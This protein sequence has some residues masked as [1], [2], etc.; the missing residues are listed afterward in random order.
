M[1][2][3]S[4]EKQNEEEG[5]PL[6]RLSPPV[7]ALLVVASL[8]LPGPT[9]AASDNAYVVIFDDASV[10]RPTADPSAARQR[11]GHF[12]MAEVD[13]ARV[14]RHVAAMERQYRVRPER[15][16]RHAV[17]GFSARLSASQ[18][19]ALR[20]DPAVAAIEPDRVVRLDEGPAAQAAYASNVSSSLQPCLAPYVPPAGTPCIPAGVRRVGATD[21]PLA[22]IDGAD[23]RVD[24]DVAIIDTGIDRNHPDLNVAGG[25]NCTTTNRSAYGDGN[26]HGTHVA[27]TVAAVDNGSGVVGVAPG[28]RLW[29]VKVLNANGSGSVSSIICGIDWVTAQRDPADVSRPLIEVANMSLRFGTLDTS[30]RDCAAPAGD[31]VLIAICRSVGGGTTYAVAAGNESNNARVYRPASYANVITV[32]ATVD[33]DGLPGGAAGRRPYTFCY[34]DPDDNFASFSS[35]GAVLQLVAPGKCV[36]STWPRAMCNNAERCYGWLSGTSMATPHVAGG[37]ALYM[38]QYPQARPQQVRMALQAAARTDWR[39]S[40]YPVSNPPRQLWL[41]QLGPPPDFDATVGAPTGSG[42]L[43]TGSS[44]SVPVSVSRSNGHSASIRLLLVGAPAGIGTSG[45]I[46][47]PS[48]SL[49]ITAS[50]SAPSGTHTF[51]VQATDGELVRASRSVTVRVD[52]VA[53][54]AAFVRP[55]SDQTSSQ[56]SRLISVAWSESDDASG[57]AGRTVQRQRGAIRTPGSC[58]GVSFS[59]K[60]TPVTASGGFTEQVAAGYCFRYLLTVRDDAGNFATATSGSV[61]IDQTAPLAPTVRL[62]GSQTPTNVAGAIN[63]PPAHRDAAG[64][65]W[66]RAGVGGSLSISVSGSDPESGV[67]TTRI[68][69]ASP[70]TGWGSWPH[71]TAAA[72]RSETLPF[73][74]DAV[75]T[76]VNVRN[77]NGAGLLG[78]ISRLN[79]RRDATAPSPPKWTAPAPTTTSTANS[80]VLNWSGASDSG[81]GLAG[82]HWVRRQVAVPNASGACSGVSWSVDGPPRMLASGTTENGLLADRC[83][84][85]RLRAADNVGNLSA[86]VGSGTVRTQSTVRDTNRSTLT[87]SRPTVDFRPAAAVTPARLARLRVGW[88]VSASNG[89]DVYQMRVS[90]NGGSWQRFAVSGPG[91]ILRLGSGSHRLAVRARDGDGN[92]SA[93]SGPAAFRLTIVEA[94][95]AVVRYAGNWRTKSI[96]GTLG[97]R[98]RMSKSAGAT[99]TLAFDGH[100]VAVV[101]VRGPKRGRAEVRINGNAPQAIDTRAGTRQLRRVVYDR[102]WAKAARRTI[103]V[104]VSGTAGRPRVD[105]DAFIVLG[106]P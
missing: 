90:T 82:K 30:Q 47:G 55:A 54:S 24:V 72:S 106:P 75:N 85:W 94:E 68:A 56:S 32:G 88:S 41:G 79:L 60:G 1:P 25:Y 98:T 39:R 49:S 92:W 53:P 10:S 5:P 6:R 34:A 12:A 77:I 22:L 65:I 21:N 3:A 35:Y 37:A 29:S 102:T 45:S 42:W 26:G 17:G 63:L 73:S 57:V 84:R 62:T 58:A 9:N 103:E 101:G 64:T 23:E 28:A 19:R 67:A 104:R 89:I 95:S 8:A 91:H 4:A 83:Y 86:V 76:S 18:L 16:F 71:E 20:A 36:L 13:G 7:L 15:V 99:A 61:L 74:R 40:T 31:G 50:A 100:S 81:S 48:G 11:R 80:V 93:W 27:G 33:Y 105:L 87:V 51:D 43:G 52:A 66:F 69:A 14:K 97:G 70:S 46:N 78:P 2:W 96:S 59:N 38:A 44:V